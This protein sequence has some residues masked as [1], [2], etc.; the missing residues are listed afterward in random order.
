MNPDRGNTTQSS[1][2]GSV[3]LTIGSALLLRLRGTWESLK[4]SPIRNFP[5]WAGILIVFGII[6]L[7]LGFACDLFTV[8]ILDIQKFWYIPALLILFP[9]IPEELLFRGL[10]ISRDSL[11]GPRK[12]T[13]AQVFLSS[14]VFTASR[15][16]FELTFGSHAQPYFL[17]PYFL[18]IVF[19]LGVVCSLGYILS[20]SIWVPIFMHWLT[21]FIWVMLLGGGDLIL[22]RAV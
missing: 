5:A 11:D 4:S 2:I 19:L 7:T 15:P 1:T 22:S 10:M 16:L 3:L 12:Y 13:A 17:S 18:S 14:A 8:R 21:A 6:A 20:R 9:S